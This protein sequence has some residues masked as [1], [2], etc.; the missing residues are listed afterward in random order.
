MSISHGKL[1][2]ESDFP[3]TLRGS[4]QLSLSVPDMGKFLDEDASGRSEEENR[5]AERDEGRVAEVT[6]E[7][8]DLDYDFDLDAAMDFFGDDM[9]FETPQ[10]GQ[11]DDFEGVTNPSVDPPL[12]SGIDDT[13]T[14]LE[15]IFGGG[16]QAGDDFDEWATRVLGLDAGPF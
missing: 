10:A 15:A 1:P 16:V 11:G 2:E 3:P 14:D 6:G 9:S 8:A 4:A 5:A 12:P 13:S 7:G